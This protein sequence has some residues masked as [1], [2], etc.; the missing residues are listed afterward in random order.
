M[1]AKDLANLQPEAKRIIKE[2]L[3]AT[4][5]TINGLSV[6]AKVHPTQLYLFLGGKRGLTDT[7]LTK[8]GKVIEK[9]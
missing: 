9:G 2:Y 1:E 4:G 5:L 6:K 7:S 8:L 3:K